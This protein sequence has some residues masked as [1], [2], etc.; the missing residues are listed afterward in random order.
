MSEELGPFASQIRELFEQLIGALPSG[1]AHLHV[2]LTASGETIVEIVPT[3]RNA[4]PVSAHIVEHVN[5]VDLT[6]G[7]A[8][9]FELPPDLNR[10]YAGETTVSLVRMLAEA[11]IA[12]E[13]QEE[14]LQGLMWRG[15][16]ATI[17]VRSEWQQHAARHYFYLGRPSKTIRSYEPYNA[18]PPNVITNCRSICR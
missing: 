1:V 4:A 7:E 8:C 16:R 6:L 18:A 3:N 10:K 15:W 12:G 2:S 14:L 5:V 13:F 17:K 11:A 9:T